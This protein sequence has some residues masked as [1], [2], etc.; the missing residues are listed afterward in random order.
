MGNVWTSG[1]KLAIRNEL[2]AAAVKALE[3]KGWTVERIPRAGKSSVRRI[4][5]GKLAKT[6]AIRTTQNTSIGFQRDSNTGKWWTLAE[7]DYVVASSVD[8]PDHPRFAQIHMLDGDDVRDRF[9]RTYAARKKAGLADGIGCWLRL[10]ERERSD[11]PYLVGAGA[12]L[13]SPPIARVPLKMSSGTTRDAGQGDT[14]DSADAVVEEGSKREVDWLDHAFQLRPDL[15]VT[16][17]LPADITT[18]EAE[19][20]AGFIRQVPFGN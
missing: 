2:F 18:K 15:R 16:I 4:I 10:Y 17:K 5:Q 13:D 3:D 1:E 20:L 8:D 14:D 12:G 6:V 19:R 9:D 11:P 7:V